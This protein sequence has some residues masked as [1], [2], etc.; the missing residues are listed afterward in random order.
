MGAA[1]KHL[2]IIAFVAMAAPVH[3]QESSPG[4]AG[5][6]SAPGKTCR[7]NSAEKRSAQDC[8]TYLR[9]QSIAGGA[10]YDDQPSD[11]TSNFLVV[12]DQNAQPG[13][14]WNLGVGKPGT[15]TSSANP[16]AWIIEQPLTLHSGASILGQ[17]IVGWNSDMTTG[18]LIMSGSRFPGALTSP[19]SSGDNLAWPAK[20]PAIVCNRTG[21][22]INTV[23]LGGATPVFVKLVEENNLQ[24]INP[25]VPRKLKPTPGPT[26]PSG[27]ASCTIPAG[28]TNGSVS[29]TAPVTLTNPNP[30]ASPAF[31]AQDYAVCASLVSGQESCGC[32]SASAG[33]CDT[34]S[35]SCVAPGV[36]DFSAGC[37][38]GAG[39]HATL[40]A[41]PSLP[42]GEKE[43][44]PDAATCPPRSGIFVPP[45][46][47]LSSVM[48]VV[49]HMNGAYLGADNTYG[50]QVKNLTL[51]CGPNG[52]SD[53]GTV[54]TPSVAMWLREAQ[55]SAQISNI[56]FMGPCYGASQYVT[57]GNMRIDG[58]YPTSPH[59][60][61]S[62]PAP[63]ATFY[64]L[65]IDGFYAAQVSAFGIYS[66]SLNSNARGG[67]ARANIYV[68]GY[69]AFPSGYSLHM[70]NNTGPGGK[71][72]DNVIVDWGANF[73]CNSCVGFPRSAPG[74]ATFHRTSTGN[75]MTIVA[76]PTQAG[77]PRVIIDDARSLVINPGVIG[78]PVTYD[79]RSYVAKAVLTSAYTNSK[80]TQ[81]S[82]VG[83]ALGVEAN[84]NYKLLC[85]GFYQ[86][87]APTAGLSWQF[88]GP[89]SAAQFEWSMHAV[90][91]GGASAVSY[92]ATA[93]G[94]SAPLTPPTGTSTAA[95]EEF[96]IEAYL[97][98]GPNPG[99]I[100]PQARPNGAGTLTIEPGMTCEL[101]PQ[102]VTP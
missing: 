12:R 6:L 38:L 30:A 39:N 96:R 4:A 9:D 37:R 61:Q 1:L 29:I 50:Q 64:N 15:N 22:S 80:A 70:E 85:H 95:D 97:R 65:V 31:D 2:V 56:Q 74:Y 86:S 17:G 90:T 92:D 14:K 25:P 89:V 52:F 75:S 32:T 94:F 54:A 35:V 36:V 47:D 33:L 73:E 20:P 3:A 68:R 98:N 53:G 60:W 81:F 51:L 83:D 18:T 91:T 102:N 59:L 79:S 28:T 26:L 57:R 69:N 62:P 82:S 27:E 42:H 44:C 8:A 66:S 77:G 93:S 67:N 55:E 43:L 21:G 101:T 45:V 100:Q 88:T 24:G 63:N 11:I 78:V 19:Y 23:A 72:G 7:V 10:I 34:Q 40:T 48:V 41:I 5:D 87:G 84:S 16:I 46:S 49:G 71:G 13:F 58:M 99:V 76:S